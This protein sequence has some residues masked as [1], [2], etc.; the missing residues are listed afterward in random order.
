[1]NHC[2]SSF[3]FNI[4]TDQC[5]N[6]ISNCQVCTTGNTCQLCQIEYY[7]DL[8]MQCVQNCPGGTFPDV[9]GFCVRCPSSCT[10]C[11]S[12][13]ECTACANGYSLENNKCVNNSNPTCPQNCDVCFNSNSCIFCENGYFLNPI[14]ESCETSCPQG[15]IAVG[16]FCRK[17]SSPCLTCN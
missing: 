6:C 3:Y 14:N 4:N 7:L 2:N 15:Y 9:S 10:N 11:S 12:Y 17:C 1:M 16:K 8:N 5:E 13:Q